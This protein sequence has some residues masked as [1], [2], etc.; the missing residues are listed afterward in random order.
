MVLIVEPAAEDI[1]TAVW[2]P[3]RFVVEP[4]RLLL[5]ENLL[6]Q[7]VQ[8]VS[9][10]LRCAAFGDQVGRLLQH[11]FLQHQ[12]ELVESAACSQG[13]LPGDRGSPR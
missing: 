6:A 2:R 9:D 11:Q 12:S 8:Y 3:S 13:H 4:T 1:E 7:F 10:L 5:G